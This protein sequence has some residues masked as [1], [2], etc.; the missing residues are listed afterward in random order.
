MKK[1]RVVTGVGGST[2]FPGHCP[3]AAS[4]TRIVSL[5]LE[6]MTT[7][8]RAGDHRRG[9]QVIQRS[10]AEIEFGCFLDTEFR[11]AI[12]AREISD[13]KTG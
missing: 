9:V 1:S 13:A 6:I 10:G 8:A 3:D 4:Q 12:R 11:G 2:L 7:T 5:Q